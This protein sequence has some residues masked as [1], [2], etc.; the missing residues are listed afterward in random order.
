MDDFKISFVCKE[1]PETMFDELTNKGFNVRMITNED[2]FFSLIT[3]DT[4]VVLDGYGFDTEYQKQI[5][6]KKCRLVCID[7]LH[8]KEFVADLI[9]NH[10]PGIVPQD[11]QALPQTQFALGL[12]YAL[13]RPAF[14][15]QAKC[16]RVIEK[17]ETLLI[18][19]GGSDFKNLT[20]QTLNTVLQ[21]RKFSKI[22]VIT[23]AAYELTNDFI[24]LVKSDSRIDHRSDLNEKQMLAAML[25]AELAI[26]PA[27]G[28]LL[29]IFCV[30]VPVISGYY[31]E[32][33]LNAA[34]A[35]NDK[36]LIYYIGNMLDN[37]KTKLVEILNSIYIKDS[38]NFVCHQKN[39][40]KCKDKTI[41][42]YFKSLMS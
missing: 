13:L 19:F 11:Y 9:I 34:V 17:I 10:A 12:E 32:N 16:N 24:Q 6:E 38:E 40:F 31:V 1:I 27:S 25:E 3:N 36:G 2:H 39:S 37:Y 22:I 20:Q 26:V 41:L 15:E 29:E 4:I 28:I 33:Q 21:F 14:L 8:D 7:D 30:G 42:E 23:G 5:K 35:L 18:C